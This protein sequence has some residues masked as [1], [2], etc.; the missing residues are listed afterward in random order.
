M[1][2]SRISSTVYLGLAAPFR[3]YEGVRMS[4][5]ELRDWQHASVEVA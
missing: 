1:T 3:D 4:S 2:N 5:V